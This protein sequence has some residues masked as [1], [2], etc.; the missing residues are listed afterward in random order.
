[1][2]IL[3]NSPSVKIV[4]LNDSKTPTKKNLIEEYKIRNI[5]RGSFGEIIT[6]IAPVTTTT[7]IAPITTTTTTIAPITTTTTTIAPITTTTTTVAPITTTT[8]VAPITT[9]TTVAPITTTTTTVAPIT[10][11]TTTVAPVTTT[12]TTILEGLPIIN[13]GDTTFYLNKAIGVSANI[14][15]NGISL[16]FIEI[17][18]NDTLTGSTII[19]GNTISGITNVISET[20]IPKITPGDYYYRIGA[21]NEVGTTYG[22]L[23]LV[24]Q[25]T[26]IGRDLTDYT[27]RIPIMSG[28]TYYIEPGALVNGNGLSPLTPYDSWTRLTAGL[29]GSRTYLQKRGTTY[30]TTLT[31][32][33][34]ITGPCTI[35][36]YGDESLGAPKIITTGIGNPFIQSDYQ[37]IIKDIDVEGKYKDPITGNFTGTCVRFKGNSIGNSWVINSKLHGFNNLIVTAPIYP[38]GNL[39][40]GAAW[41]GATFVYNEL[42]D[43]STDAVFI[44]DTTGVEVAHCN[45]HDINQIY[46]YNQ[47]DNVS[48]GDGI[49]IQFGPLSTTGGTFT[50]YT[51]GGSLTT[52]VY[53]QNLNVNIHHNTI[54]RTTSG[55]KFCTIIAGN[56]VGYPNSGTINNNEFIATTNFNTVNLLSLGRSSKIFNVYDNY[57]IGGNIGV[58]NETREITGEPTIHNNIFDGNMLCIDNR[59]GFSNMHNNTYVNYV[60]YA[61]GIASLYNIK[62]NYNIFKGAVASQVVYGS[63][64][65]AYLIESDYNCYDSTILNTYPTLANFRTFAGMDVNSI[66]TDPLFTNFNDKIYSLEIGSPC[67]AD[68]I[69]AIPYI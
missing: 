49:Q 13:S 17:A 12:T 41:S 63:A 19:S 39:L 3:Y 67:I 22:E 62:S 50:G 34:N 58:L 48:G 55:N 8:T 24:K 33:R 5:R 21:T 44:N 1:M 30:N 54:D 26:G 43:A 9:T 53:P 10:T 23:T 47:V 66:E 45:I 14:V 52:Y 32:L 16:A 37:L 65:I 42:Y 31:G 69:G 2:K 28:N 35:G 51:T 29:Y 36:A 60:D 15:P 25:Y 20:I 6:T 7:T 56:G 40:E 64:N 4:E 11:T 38:G 57:F 27:T 46:F 59:T 68:N 61:Y 18:D